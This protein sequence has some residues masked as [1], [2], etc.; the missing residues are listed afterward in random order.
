MGLPAALFAFTDVFL[1]PIT[2]SML[3][4]FALRCFGQ[5]TVLQFHRDLRH[6]SCHHPPA[7]PTAPP[8]EAP[9]TPPAPEAEESEEED[10]GPYP[11]LID[12]YEQLAIPESPAP[13]LELEQE[14]ELV[15]ESGH[16]YEFWYF[17]EWF[18]VE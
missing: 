16:L 11:N 4:G 6:F 13:K 17:P 15:E 2:V 7:A 14:L 8:T 12:M 3:F 1:T 9:P 10:G 18:K 5:W